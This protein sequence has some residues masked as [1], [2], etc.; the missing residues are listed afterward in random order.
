MSGLACS[1]SENSPKWTKTIF[2]EVV[3]IVVEVTTIKTQVEHPRPN[4]IIVR[5]NLDHNFLGALFAGLARRLIFF[6]FVF[7]ES[8]LFC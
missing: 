8:V 4:N 7:Q 5:S 3:K 1:S 2:Q 6:L